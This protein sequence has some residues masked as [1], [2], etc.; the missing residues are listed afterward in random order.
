MEW[1]Q[2]NFAVGVQMFNFLNANFEIV[3]IISENNLSQ[4][5]EKNHKQSYTN[6]LGF[7]LD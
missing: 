1:G 2:L 3:L 4:L 5:I 6:I 7:A